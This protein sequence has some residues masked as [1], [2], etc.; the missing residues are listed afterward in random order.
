MFVS[1]GQKSGSAPA[2]NAMQLQREQTA[3]LTLTAMLTR[4][5][6]LRQRN[7]NP[8]KRFTFNCYQNEAMRRL[9]GERLHKRRL[10]DQKQQLRPHV[11]RLEMT[12]PKRW[13]L[14]GWF[15]SDS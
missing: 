3:T 14:I 10:F 11:C 9:C 4:W 6:W 8:T 2:A 7:P 1:R 15:K 5:V 13:Q 12:N